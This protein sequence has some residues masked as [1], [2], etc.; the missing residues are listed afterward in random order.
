MYGDGLIDAQRA[1]DVE[2]RRHALASNRC[3][4]TT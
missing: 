3:A 1:V 2:R 4:S